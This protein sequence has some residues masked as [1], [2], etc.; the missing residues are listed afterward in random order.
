MERTLYEGRT[1]YLI[2]PTNDASTIKDALTAAGIESS[3]TW[4]RRNIV[5]TLRVV[6]QI[7][8]IRL[9]GKEFDVRSE[10]FL[11]GES[12]QRQ[13]KILL[14]DLAVLSRHIIFSA[15]AAP[16]ANRV[17]S[18]ELSHASLL[19][20]FNYYRQTCFRKNS[21]PGI[22]DLVSQII[23]SPHD[24]LVEEH[25][26]DQIWN[27]KK[28]SRKTLKSLFRHDQSFARLHSSHPLAKGRPGL[29][30]VGTDAILFPLKALRARGAVTVDTP[31]NRFIKHV[32]L[33]IENVCRSSLND[34]VLSGS[35][36]KECVELLGLSRSLLR[37]PFFQGI[38]R[39]TAIPISSPALSARYGYRD[40]YRIFM[41]SRMGAKHLFS[42]MAESALV[43][44]LK[45]VSLLYEYW[46]FY[47]ICAALLR[48]GAMFLSRSAIVKDGRIVNSA[49][50]SDGEWSV[51]FNK[52]YT[53]K[54]GGS[55]SLRFRP[56]IVIERV[57]SNAAAS[58]LHVLDAK[59]K[60]QQYTVE[61]EEDDSLSKIISIVKPADIHKM[62]CYSDAIEGVETATA[63]YPGEEFI[64]YPRD[65]DA[66]PATK[67]NQ[68]PVLKGVGAVPLMP[69]SPNAVFAEFIERLRSSVLR[70]NEHTIK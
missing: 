37:L 17:H 47:K 55:Y 23:S 48:P 61:D 15:S 58:L 16:G 1:Y 56:D 25:V 6:N 68:I 53:R 67:P 60:N 8:L 7:G 14:D 36:L 40:F 43:V 4:N 18:P 49:I 64:F 22:A 70:P 35:L 59:Y 42:D 54:T 46:V 31:E 38:S 66:S 27:A 12:G 13:F 19:E 10:K 44:E 69:G 9:F 45:D 41:Q 2:F 33:D 65:R 50:V 28:P 52:T 30:I 57:G 20:R 3:V 39:L 21:S 32:L 24:R 26:H 62:H 63:I 34:G 5:A 51:H 11:E 29:K